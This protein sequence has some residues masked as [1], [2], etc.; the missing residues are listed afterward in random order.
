FPARGLATVD[1]DNDGA[2]DVVVSNSGAAPLVLRNNGGHRAGFV[3][4]ELVTT[5]SA[6]GAA[7]A[8][9]RWRAGGKEF[10]RLRTAGGSY[11]SSHDPR[12]VLGL[13]GAACEWIEVRW[14]SGIVDRIAAPPAGRYSRLV[15]GQG[16][17]K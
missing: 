7:G 12:E 15:E 11:L 16:I 8:S 3:G 4:L 1:L 13:G 6:P 10:S 14:P 17:G 5:K 2:V 9:I